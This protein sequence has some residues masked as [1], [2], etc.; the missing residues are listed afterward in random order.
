MVPF[1]PHAG[2]RFYCCLLLVAL[3]VWAACVGGC[4]AVHWFSELRLCRSSLAGIL[5]ECAG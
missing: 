1:C 4:H 3:T 2:C 5:G